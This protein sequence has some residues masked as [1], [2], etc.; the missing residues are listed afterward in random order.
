MYMDFLEYYLIKGAI[1][2]S[3]EGMQKLWKCY[4]EDKLSEQ[5]P[6]L[7]FAVLLKESKSYL[8]PHKFALFSDSVAQLFFQE[9]LCKCS[10]AAVSKMTQLG[11]DCFRTYLNWVN[12][13]DVSSYSANPDYT[14]AKPSPPIKATI[15]KLQGWSTLWSIAC[16]AETPMVREHAKTCL[17]DVMEKL[18]IKHKAK[19]KEVVQR[20][21]ETAL[22]QVKD[23]SNVRDV[24]IVLK[25]MEAIID[26]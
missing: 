11:F 10:P 9:I 2:L 18:C 24:Q 21:L 8:N 17:V 3:K 12:G 1:D 6:N 20:A 22:D 16:Q 4:V 23:L 19:R 25:I 7:L 15:D 14:L 13:K 5:H 26:K